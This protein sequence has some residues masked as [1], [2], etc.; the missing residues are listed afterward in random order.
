MQRRD[1]RYLNLV[2]VMEQEGYGICDSMY[3]VKEEGEGLNGL[4]LVDGQQ[5]VDEMIRKYESSKKVVLTVMRDKMKHAIVVSPVKS[6]QSAR[7]VSKSC[8]TV[9]DLEAGEEQPKY[10]H[11]STQIGRAHV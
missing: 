8:A 7:F 6:K 10:D 2:T 5:K 9:I 3:Y 1:V 11:V 4:D